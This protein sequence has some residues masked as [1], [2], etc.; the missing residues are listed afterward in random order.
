MTKFLNSNGLT[1]LIS[2][3]KKAL[4]TKQDTLVSG[5]NIK[6]V[7]RN[8]L[9]GNG[10]VQL[11]GSNLI[12]TGNE[13]Y[14]LQ[15]SDTIDQSLDI[16]DEITYSKQD[17]LVSGTNIKTINTKSLVGS[18]DVVLEATD[19][20]VTNDDTN[21]L[22]VSG[23]PVEDALNA[24]SG[25]VTSKQANLVSGTNIKT[26]NGTSLLGSGNI[27]INGGTLA[28]T[29]ADLY[30]TQT[31]GTIDDEIDALDAMKAREVTF[32]KKAG[33]TS[34]TFTTSSRVYGRR[35]YCLSAN[36]TTWQAINS[37]TFNT[38]SFNTVQ[39]TQITPAIGRTLP[40]VGDKVSEYYFIFFAG[41]NDM[42]ITFP[43]NIKWENG[44][45]PTIKA[46]D[47]CELVIRNGIASLRRT[48]IQ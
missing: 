27:A 41:I 23:D 38:G 6:T 20:N 43:S 19:I 47:F 37:L 32:T 36:A 34:I 46:N 15:V 9:L 28:Y 10:D 1:R 45:K 8:S 24:L 25:A 44:E 39:W 3:I 33:S 42:P 12:Y 48:V 5:T 4:S 16:L 22:W 29:G 40:A 7:N 11:D 2:I 21:N 18:G 30:D 26:V 14:N 35:V 31:G 17:R 13:S